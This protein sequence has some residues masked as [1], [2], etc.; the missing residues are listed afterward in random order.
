MSADRER[1][2]RRRTERR[3]SNGLLSMGSM[4]WCGCCGR[5]QHSTR[6][7]KA[8]GGWMLEAWGVIF[9]GG[10][11]VAMIMVLSVFLI[12]CEWQLGRKIAFTAP[13]RAAEF[14]V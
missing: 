3:R 10:A 2:M 14:A 4:R 11:C 1:V 8:V 9:D 5:R 12:L 13:S 6:S 7:A